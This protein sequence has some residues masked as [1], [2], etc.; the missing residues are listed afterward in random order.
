MAK[1]TKR[2]TV[3]ER[4]MLKNPDWQEG[5]RSFNEL[6][7]RPLGWIYLFDELS[8]DH[9]IRL[10]RKD[11]SLFYSVSET[12]Q[13]SIEDFIKKFCGIYAHDESYIH[14]FPLF[15]KDAFGQSCLIFSL[16][17]IG[18]LKGFLLLTSLHGPQKKFE[19]FLKPFDSFLASQVDL[20]FRTFEL[21]NFYE[22]V[23]P[24]AL[25]LSTMHSVHRVISTSLRL[26][27]LLP[28]IGRLSTQVLKAKGCS[29]MLCDA[30][31]EYL[32]PYF[33]SESHPKF[34]HEQRIKI[35][36]GVMGGVAKTGNFHYTRNSIAVPFIEEDVVGVIALWDKLAGQSF[37]RTDL[38]I[39]KS[40]SEQT[41]VAIKNAQLYEETEQLTLGSIKAINELLASNI[42]RNPKEFPLILD[43]IR[44]IGKEMGLNQKDLTIVERAVM[45]VDAGAVLSPG[46]FWQKRGKLSKK[47][48][49][50]IKQIPQKGA[51]LLKSIKSLRPYL[52]IITHYRERYDGRGYPEGLK[53]DFIPVGSRIIAVVDSF[54]AMISPRVYRD[55]LT[56]NQAVGEIQANRGSQFD[57]QVVDSFLNVVRR[58][59]IA[60][61][62]EEIRPRKSQRVS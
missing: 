11:Y 36:R 42:S 20:A 4:F 46:S 21:N 9:L 40:L 2:E 28:R 56:T 31:H 38:E 57:P 16:V 1:S 8:Q 54:V 58:Y 55:S 60:Q 24:R 26:S 62:I 22:T 37:T 43:L 19:P 35:G 48:I 49:G 23:H 13:N 44:E 7:G 14:K 33:A 15:F 39:L 47:E 29:V 61:R 52:P 50:L 34:T 5:Y 3:L 17:H 30:E 27:E 53:G 10:D 41:V 12:N 25:A 6:Y 51:N 32:I 59:D 45:L 18:N